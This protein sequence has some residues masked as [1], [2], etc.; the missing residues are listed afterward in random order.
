MASKKRKRGKTVKGRKVAKRAAKQPVLKLPAS[1]SKTIS[2]AVAGGVDRAAGL[3][4]AA[5]KDRVAQEPALVPARTF[6]VIPKP[7]TRLA[8]VS[9]EQKHTKNLGNFE[10]MSYG[11]GLTI[12]VEIEVTDTIESAETRAKLRT[13]YEVTIKFLTDMLKEMGIE[14]DIARGAAVS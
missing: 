12:P 4:L 10:S 7:E 5:V 6:E 2:D 13:K 8:F 1:F 3:V 11:C 14:V 9:S